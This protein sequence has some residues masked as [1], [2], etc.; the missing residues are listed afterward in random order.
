MKLNAINKTHT[1]FSSRA[2]VGAGLSFFILSSNKL[3]FDNGNNSNNASNQTTF[4]YI[5]SKD[6]WYHIAVIQTSTQKKLY[7]NGILQQSIDKASANLGNNT[8]SKCTIGASG[9]A[10]NATDNWLN[11]YLNDVRIYDHALS[12]KEVEEISKGLVLHYKLD[13]IVNPNLLIDSNA[14]SLT[15]VNATHNRYLEGAS[16]GSYTVTFE[17]LTDPPEIGIKYGVRQKNTSGSSMHSVTWYSGLNISVSATPYTM[18]CYV[19]RISEETNLKIKF[20]Y[21]KSPYKSTFQNIIND[22]EWHKYSWTFTPETA[23]GEAAASGTTKIYPG[24][25][26]VSPGEVLICGWKLEEGSAATPWILNS[27]EPGYSDLFNI[28][29]IVYDSSGYNNDGTIIGSLSATTDTARYNCA[30]QMN[31][32]STNNHIECNNELNLSS[33]NDLTITFWLYPKQSGG[34]VAYIDKDMSFCVNSTGT[35]FYVNRVS[36]KGFPAS[37][38][39]INDWNFITLVRQNSNILVYINLENIQRDSSSSSTNWSHNSSKMYLLNRELN[40]N[41][42][43]NAAISDFRIYATALTEEQIKELYNTSVTIDNL[44]NIHAREF[45]ENSNLNITKTGLFQATE[46]KDGDYQIASILKNTN[47]IQGNNLYEY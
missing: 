32:I 10:N 35:Y 24:G 40:N 41:Y 37:K 30:A 25:L 46:I 23:S 16:S 26:S 13:N 9:S 4:N 2:A 45:D 8:A 17:E 15:K 3:R 28:Y 21:G 47:S 6:I 11:G 36:S 20:Q 31:N 5:F 38:I 39:K 7:I 18:S 12:D 19:K 14:P 29:N 44:G 22:H 27:V 33:N 1:L 43:A 42:A 34:Y